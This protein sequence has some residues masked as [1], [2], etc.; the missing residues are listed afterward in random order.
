MKKYNIGR[1]GYQDN[2]GRNIKVNIRGIE[3]RDNTEEFAG[4]W[5]ICLGDITEF[6]LNEGDSRSFIFE[7][8]ENVQLIGEGSVQCDGKGGF[9]LN[10][11]V[12]Y[13]EG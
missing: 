4:Y 2:Y 6:T 13:I 5:E 8:V 7:T 1:L 9:N 12:L 11:K 3:L 10:G